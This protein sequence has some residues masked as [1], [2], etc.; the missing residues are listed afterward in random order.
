[1]LLITQP[2]VGTAHNEILALHTAARSL[3][4]DVLPAPTSWR[5][6]DSIISASPVGSPYGSQTFCEVVAHQVGWVL[7]GNPD[8]WLAGLPREFLKRNVEITTVK[9]AKTIKRRAFMKPADMKFFDAKVY[10]RGL[11]VSDHVL[12]DSPVLV[13]DPVQFTEEYRC[14]V[15]DGRVASSSCYIYHGEI[16]NPKNYYV[17]VEES[18]EFANAVLKDVA[19]ENA[20]MDVGVMEDGWAVIESNQIWASGLYGCDPTEVLKTIQTACARRREDHVDEEAIP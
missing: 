7:K 12:D 5:I 19:S 4:W 11:E 20:V 6:E 15:R 17:R 3:G 2:R 16:A 8:G 14:I 10:E 9:E 13:S 18:E 1:M